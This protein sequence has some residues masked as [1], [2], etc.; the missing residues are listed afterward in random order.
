MFSLAKR[1]AVIKDLFGVGSIGE[2]FRSGKGAWLLFD[3]NLFE[4]AVAHTV[5]GNL[6][7]EDMFGNKYYENR[8][9]PYDRCRWVVYADKVDYNATSIPPE[10]HGWVNYINDYP[11]TTHEYKKPIYAI[12]PYITRTG[13]SGAYQPKGA[14][15]NTEQRKWKKM[16]YWQ[17]PSS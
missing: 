17:P 6:I 12:Q 4:T 1:L 5:K 11:P 3:G 10:W 15:S 14:W 7:G 16:Q 13:T 2:L 9:L 8:D